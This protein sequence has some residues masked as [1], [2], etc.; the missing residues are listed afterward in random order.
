MGIGFS[1]IELLE[2][3]N[4]WHVYSDIIASAESQFKQDTEKNAK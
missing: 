1:P 3:P 2:L 4:L